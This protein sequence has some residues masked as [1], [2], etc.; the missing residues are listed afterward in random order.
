MKVLH[1]NT[2][3]TVGGASRGAYWVHQ[4]LIQLGI[5]SKMLVGH[6]SS[7]DPTILGPQYLTISQKI[8][9]ELNSYID[10]FPLKSYKNK[11]S[12]LFSPATRGI[13]LLDNIKSFNP[14]VIN[15]HW[16]CESFLKPETLKLL[17]KPIVW[18][19][20]DMWPMTGGCH[21]SYDCL[22]YT[23]NCGSCPQLGS[24]NPKDISWKLIR[25]K[26]KAWQDLNLSLIA[27]SQWMADCASKSRLFHKSRIEIIPSGVDLD[28]TFYPRCRQTLRQVLGLPND[29][30][31]LL[32]VAIKAFDDKRKGWKYLLTALQRLSQQ[33]LRK[34][35]QMVI[36]GNETKPN[37]NLDFPVR[38]L[39]SLKDDLTLSLFYGASDVLVVPSLQDNLPKVP[40]ESFACG[41]PVVAFDTTGLKDVIDHKLN[42]Y[43]AKCFDSQDLSQGISWVLDNPQR[44]QSLC[45]SARRKAKQNFS[46]IGQAE[47]CLAYYQSLVTN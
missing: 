14:D 18:T 19:L 26:E 17:D 29:H 23:R 3:D 30:Y 20:R 42:G 21:Y 45:D 24:K 13:E 41:T 8:L 31:I 28:K 25:R 15:L 43:L 35:L 1:L 9:Y 36:I 33:G 10:T 27:P 7:K 16:T 32:F 2:W 47:S 6:R 39:G 37:F 22:E 44:H 11:T 5:N 40:I 38:A 12:D 46:V 4:A 34:P